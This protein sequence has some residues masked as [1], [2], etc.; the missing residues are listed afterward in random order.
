MKK[1]SVIIFCKAVSQ[2]QHDQQGS[3]A[4]SMDMESLHSLTTDLLELS[5]GTQRLLQ[6]KSGSREEPQL[7]PL[8]T[9]LDITTHIQARHST[10]VKSIAEQLTHSTK[11]EEKLVKLWE[12]LCERTRSCYPEAEQAYDIIK[13]QQLVPTPKDF[14]SK[15]AVQVTKTSPISTKPKPAKRKASALLKLQ[16]PEGLLQ[17][18]A[19]KALEDILKEYKSFWKQALAVETQRWAAIRKKDDFPSSIKGHLKTLG[20]QTKV[21]VIDAIQK[22]IR[23]IMSYIAEKMHFPDNPSTWIA[24]DTQI[25]AYFEHYKSLSTGYASE[26]ML[27]KG[28]F[29]SFETELSVE[30][31]M[32]KPVN[33]FTEGLALFKPPPAH[34]IPIIHADMWPLLESHGDSGGVIIADK[35][36]QSSKAL[37]PKGSEDVLHSYAKKILSLQ[38]GLTATK[39]FLGALDVSIKENKDWHRILD[40]SL[41]KPMSQ[42]F[43]RCHEPI[44]KIQKNRQ[45]FYSQER[46]KELLH[47][48]SL[49]KMVPNPIVF[50]FLITGENIGPVFPMDNN[51]MLNQLIYKVLMGRLVLIAALHDFHHW[52]AMMIYLRIL[53]RSIDLTDGSTI[54]TKIEI[55]LSVIDPT[56]EP[57][58]VPISA[59]FQGQ[60]QYVE[61]EMQGCTLVS[62]TEIIKLALCAASPND[63]GPWVVELLKMLFER[64]AKGLN[65]QSFLDQLSNLPPD[66]VSD[67]LLQ[68][69]KNHACGYN[70]L[71]FKETPQESMH[72]ASFIYFQSS[73]IISVQVHSNLLNQF[74]S[75]LVEECLLDK[76][77]QM[78]N[79]DL[80]LIV[81]FMGCRQSFARL[82][83]RGS[84]D[85][86]SKSVLGV[87]Y[88]TKELHLV[89]QS[90]LSIHNV[91]C[92]IMTEPYMLIAE[93]NQS[94][95]F[96]ESQC[97]SSITVP[98]SFNIKTAVIPIIFSKV[99]DYLHW[100]FIV[101]DY[102]TQI[103][104][105]VDTA[106]DV[107]AAGIVH[108]MLPLYMQSW[109]FVLSSMTQTYSDECGPRGVGEVMKIIEHSNISDD[110]ESGPLVQSITCLTYLLD[111]LESEHRSKTLFEQWK[112]AALYMLRKAY[113][114]L[115]LPHVDLETDEA[116][117]AQEIIGGAYYV[118]TL[119]WAFKA[120]R[121]KISIA[122]HFINIIGS[123]NGMDFIPYG[124]GG[125]KKDDGDGGGGYYAENH[126][127]CESG[128]NAV[129]L[130]GNVSK[131]NMT[132]SG[133]AV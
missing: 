118:D 114:E 5:G 101:I 14:G 33:F 102:N 125:S 26:E 64:H 18:E 35:T 84:K 4:Q 8:S 52:I 29:Q 81:K 68:I 108:E 70:L 87:M 110:P 34:S 107:A 15:D 36:K 66:S 119:M 57:S 85:H 63:S 73:T 113:L 38:G 20:K 71:F 80:P 32:K 30:E 48:E 69:R 72:T 92:A 2:Q 115:I 49:R 44:D 117:G 39:L 77:F 51:F 46:V 93:S 56:G 43:E 128:N 54:P 55:V 126:L 133:I 83:P 47:P 109:R 9:I 124:L 88:T 58:H 11:P 7:K 3:I 82:M 67:L 16:T 25:H 23:E 61:R 79:Y 27:K 40:I 130:M 75:W 90:M 1:V 123:I 6:I 24:Y 12:A 104:T 131:V 105:L 98:C 116:Q 122:G 95:L 76:I 86:S 28:F 31:L 37:L 62:N 127:P 100:M 121:S 42:L 22:K 99:T 91:D 19:H 65:I 112:D 45:K 41:L 96:T 10:Y 106:Q 17:E 21:Q 111:G 13:S 59:V 50:A 120:V 60:V 129:C 78:L 89:F 74:V 103:I 53:E 132:E 97:L 94:I